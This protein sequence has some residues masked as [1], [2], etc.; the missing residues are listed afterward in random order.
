MKFKVTIEET[1][2]DEFD[3]EA[4]SEQE[5]IELAIVK[6]DNGEYVLEP[7]NLTDKRMLIADENGKSNKEW[8]SF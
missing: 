8:V 1:I 7:G 6:Y 5:A 3:I 2:R 4:D